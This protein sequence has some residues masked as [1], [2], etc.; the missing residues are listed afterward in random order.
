MSFGPTV[1][2][3]G[4]ET[5][6]SSQ[7]ARHAR[8]KLPTPPTDAPT[9]QTIN[10]PTVTSRSHVMSVSQGQTKCRNIHTFSKRRI[11]QVHE[12]VRGEDHLRRQ[13]QECSTNTPQ[14]H[15]T[16]LHQNEFVESPRETRVH[17]SV[18]TRRETAS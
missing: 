14:Q 6:R 13:F 7:E 15:H 3:Q 8:S 12:H 10:N 5:E 11:F 2:R 9:V 1:F 18:P 16:A 4:R 17:D